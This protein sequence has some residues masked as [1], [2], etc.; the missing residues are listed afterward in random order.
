VY[1][2][3]FPIRYIS[4]PPVHPLMY[5]YPPMPGQVSLPSQPV[6]LP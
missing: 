4:A 6:C 2:A 5:R 3:A 1:T